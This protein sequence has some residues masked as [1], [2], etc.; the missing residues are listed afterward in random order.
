MLYVYTFLFSLRV[1]R[2]KEGNEKTGNFI[3][4]KLL[5]ERSRMPPG[6]G[7][8]RRRDFLAG[9]TEWNLLVG[10]HIRERH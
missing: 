4:K 1:S 2:S 6:S 9:I 8:Y 7:Q 3:V 5:P 10:G